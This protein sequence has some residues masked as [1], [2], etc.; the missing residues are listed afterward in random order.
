MKVRLQNGLNSLSNSQ[1]KPA[2]ISRIKGVHNC[3]S[4]SDLPSWKKAG[5][6]RL[7]R[8]QPLA[9]PACKPAYAGLLLF[10]FFVRSL[11]LFP[12]ELVPARLLLFSSSFAFLLPALVLSHCDYLTIPEDR[13]ATTATIL[14]R[15]LHPLSPEATVNF[16]SLPDFNH[17]FHPAPSIYTC[18]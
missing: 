1:E 9:S 17:Y 18:S 14:N 7:R 13:F 11:H 16:R 4:R 15:S 2:L 3:C 8:L 6:S 12:Q 5:H 10:I